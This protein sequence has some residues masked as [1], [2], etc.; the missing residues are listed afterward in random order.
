MLTTRDRFDEKLPGFTVLRTSTVKLANRNC[1][2]ILCGSIRPMSA[3]LWM[4]T[5][6][7]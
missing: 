3:W 7:A 2:W 4:A 5:A 6:I 1:S